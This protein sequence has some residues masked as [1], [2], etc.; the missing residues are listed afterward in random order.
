MT[1]LRETKSWPLASLSK[2][3]QEIM[4]KAKEDRPTWVNKLNRTNDSLSWFKGSATQ[5]GGTYK[6]LRDI[7]TEAQEKLTKIIESQKMLELN[8]ARSEQYKRK[9]EELKAKLDKQKDQRKQMQGVLN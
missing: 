3:N 5:G 2:D 6:K 9:A 1:D 8:K 4:N 7:N